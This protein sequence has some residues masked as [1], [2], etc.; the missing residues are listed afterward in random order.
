M[1][2]K[3]KVS[4]EELKEIHRVSSEPRTFANDLNI[5]F[6]RLLGPRHHQLRYYSCIDYELQFMTKIYTVELR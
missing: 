2:R 3:V 5:R 6:E 4:I 1:H